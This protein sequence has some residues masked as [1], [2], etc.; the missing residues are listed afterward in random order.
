[1]DLEGNA[2]VSGQASAKDIF[3]E[4][5]D[6][7]FTSDGT[8]KTTA[9][10]ELKPGEGESWETGVSCKAENLSAGLDYTVTVKLTDEQK[11]KYSVMPTSYTGKVGE[12]NNANVQVDESERYISRAPFTAI[13]AVCK[14]TYGGG[15]L[16]YYSYSDVRGKQWHVPAVFKDLSSAVDA[17]Q[18]KLYTGVNLSDSE[19]NGAQSGVSIEMLVENYTLPS[20]VVLPSDMSITLKTASEYAAMYPY[21]GASA[22]VSTIKRDDGYL[23]APMFT[24][25]NALT[26]TGIH[27]DGAAKSVS[28]DGGIVH[29]NNGGGLTIRNSAELRNSKTTGSGGAI[30][31]ATGGNLNITGGTITG[32]SALNGGAVYIAKDGTGSMS[33]GMIEKNRVSTGGKGAGIYLVTGST[34]NLSGSPGFGSGMSYENISET[35]A[36]YAGNLIAQK[37]GGKS[38]NF[39]HQDIYLEE[40][41]VEPASLVLKSN[42]EGGQG[43]IWIWAD[44]ENTNRCAMAS[45]F[46]KI[47]FR[48]AVT[49]QTYHIF[50]NAQTDSVTFVSD[51]KYLTGDNEREKDGFIHWTGGYD[52]I[53]RK[54]DSF[55]KALAGATFTLYT[56]AS[57]DN[58]YQRNGDMT[59]VSAGDGTVSSNGTSI[60]KGAV[61]FEKL[62]AGV[63]YM[64]E[65]AVPNGYAENTNTYILLVG[66]GEL[67]KYTD[68]GLTNPDDITTQTEKYQTD[69]T[70]F[71]VKGDYALF[72]YENGSAKAQPYI[73]TYGVMNINQAKRQA[74]LRKVGE[75]GFVSLSGVQFK[76]YRADRTEVKEPAYGYDSGNGYYTSGAGGVF[77]VGELNY[78]IY[79]VEEVDVPVGS[80]YSK[81]NFSFTV[82]ENGV[83]YQYYAQE[84]DTVPITTRIAWPG[85]QENAG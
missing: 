26:L 39:E 81:G 58:V 25:N 41:G 46:A 80:G 66:Q 51:G 78:G 60:P 54:V 4:Y 48:E 12:N 68:Y 10:V 45:P 57:C 49:D 53:F 11:T 42:L 17:L 50:R 32:N 20:D 33:G 70:D 64:K 36:N 13:L 71:N 47:D 65:T 6:M 61:L 69:Y 63:Y 76:I 77:F 82:D 24:A 34:L 72:L 73:A 55:G 40:T 5:G 1:M 19:Y 85:N 84:G 52:V 14:L 44:S 21:R 38:Y 3:G 23:E 62:P 30:Y 31:I 67:G 37:N 75:D 16:L 8:N 74:I 28:A 59:A 7:F 83:N 2:T 27:L 15:N 35:N 22:T 43:S 79:Y 56:D 29:V 9:T 18:R